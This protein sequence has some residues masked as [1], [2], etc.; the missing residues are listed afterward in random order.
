MQQ[1]PQGGQDLRRGL[2][3][4]GQQ[5]Q[6]THRAPPARGARGAVP[7]WWRLRLCTVR[8][9]IASV[10]PRS[11]RGHVRGL[12]RT[13]GSPACNNEQETQKDPG[14]ASPESSSGHHN[15]DGARARGSV[16]TPDP[17]A[18]PGDSRSETT[19]TLLH[20]LNTSYGARSEARRRT[21][22]DPVRPGGTGTAARPTGPTAPW[23]GS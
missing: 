13:V 5:E 17:G 22:R 9:P 21:P 8:S 11:P 10:P 19:R 23:D 6:G 3:G 7:R 14:A 2:E 15:A 1:Q 16:H 4:V 12:L 20:T 18:L